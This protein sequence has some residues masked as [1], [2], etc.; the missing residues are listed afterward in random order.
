MISKLTGG[1]SVRLL[2][3][4]KTKD[5][6]REWYGKMSIDVGDSFRAIDTIEYWECKSTGFRWYSPDQ[7]VGDGA[8]YEQLSKND[9][10][11]IPKKW[12]FCA[13]LELIPEHA[14][15]LEVGAGEGHFISVAQRSGLSVQGVE[16][17]SK[18][19]E[20]ARSQGFIVYE[21]PLREIMAAAEKEFDVICSFQVLEH[22]P[23]PISFLRDMID[24]VQSGG[25]IILSVPNA[26]VM[27]KIDPRNQDLLNKPPHH[28]GHWDIRVFRALEKILPV[29]V[30]SFSKE[31]LAAYHVAWMVTGYF[32]SL[33][34]PLG[35]NIAQIVANRY[36]TLPIQWLMR[37][38]FRSLFPGHTLLVELEVL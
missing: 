20:R 34:S 37:L 17:N 7:A 35:E 15:V 1:D 30:K 14:S 9:W 23:D 22:I 36:T 11:Y 18:A 24:I 28:L 38:G 3:R 12:E 32:R 31:P 16:L 27:R 25:K 5:I 2:S 10:Y 13:A 21:L 8:L 6:S 33:L 29:K 26:E 19:A 4:D